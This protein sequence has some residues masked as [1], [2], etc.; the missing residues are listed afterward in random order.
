M[1]QNIKAIKTELGK[2]T[3]KKSNAISLNN[4]RDQISKIEPDCRVL[5]DGLASETLRST[6]LPYTNCRLELSG[7]RHQE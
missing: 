6:C 4:K 3:T 1:N 2:T 5:D 7:L